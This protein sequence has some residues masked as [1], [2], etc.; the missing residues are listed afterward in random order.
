[1]KIISYICFIYNIT[2][3]ANDLE[4]AVFLRNVIFAP[5]KI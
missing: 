3:A 4:D 2:I 1:M 5:L